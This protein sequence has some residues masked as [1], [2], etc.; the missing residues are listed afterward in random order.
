M[1]NAEATE[2]EKL[3]TIIEHLTGVIDGGY[4]GECVWIGDTLAYTSANTGEKHGSNL[5]TITRLEMLA[6]YDRAVTFL[7]EHSDD[8]D[9]GLALYET[10]EARP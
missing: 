1:T 5:G 2:T 3:D 4:P 9:M 8:F 7:E 6:W 10:A